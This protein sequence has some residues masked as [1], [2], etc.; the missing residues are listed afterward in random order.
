MECIVD[1]RVSGLDNTTATI[2]WCLEPDN[3]TAVDTT[4]WT[5]SPVGA[6][7]GR[8]VL[9]VPLAVYGSTFEIYQTANRA[10][11]NIG[12][13]VS[14]ALIGSPTVPAG[15]A[16]TNPVT[17]R[18][19]NGMTGI[20]AVIRRIDDGLYWDGS[21][22][23]WGST[24]PSSSVALAEISSGL[25]FGNAGFVPGPGV[26]YEISVQTSGGTPII[27]SQHTYS[28]E[29]K[30][31]LEHVNDVQTALRMPRS[32]DFTASHAKL[33]LS[34]INKAIL[35]MVENAVWPEMKC[36][37]TLY[38]VAD[39]ALYQL[40]PANTQGAE[41]VERL[42]ISGY[43]PIEIL[44]DVAFRAYKQTLTTNARPIVARIYGR[45]GDALL[46]ELAPTPDAV[47]EIEFDSVLKVAML[48]NTTDVPLLD[49]AM[50]LL[51]GTAF[52]KKEQG[53]AFNDDMQIFTAKVQAQRDNISEPSW[54][55]AETI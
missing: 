36:Q 42:Q 2:A 12:V 33:V 40:R 51:G 9:S 16:Y 55:D 5:L 23:T 38:T 53:E 44:S 24:V 45:M 11:Y 15:T 27:K 35:L 19:Q 6:D 39:R 46:I 20:K 43:D 54:G 13:L 22:L 48:V 7:E 4:G 50:V 52:A 49:D 26:T 10:N 47:Y 21:T 17:W 8:Y 18:S 34:E 37:G 32:A 41:I 30:T 3:T 25:Y 14:S 29:K 31:A 1:L 28:G